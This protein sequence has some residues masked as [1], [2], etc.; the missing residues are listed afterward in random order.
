LAR[1]LGRRFRDWDAR[2]RPALGGYQVSFVPIDQERHPAPGGWQ[3]KRR[4]YRELMTL[5]PAGH[6]G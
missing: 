3:I 2:G 5:R 6:A 4:F 1:E